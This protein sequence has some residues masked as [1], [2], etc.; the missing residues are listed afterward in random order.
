MPAC[1]GSEL[2]SRDA[3]VL[4]DLAQPVTEKLPGL[5]NLV[6]HGQTG[7]CR[8]CGAGLVIASMTL[9]LVTGIISALLRAVVYPV[10]GRQVL[11]ERLRDSHYRLAVGNVQLREQ[12]G[13]VH[14][15][16]LHEKIIAFLVQAW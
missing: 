12:L 13:F 9:R 4:P 3:R 8:A 11:P 6:C 7:L 14:R 2:P 16:T 10:S 5:L 15:I 1:Q